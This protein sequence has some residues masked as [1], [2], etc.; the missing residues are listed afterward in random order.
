M[1]YA[2][3]LYLRALRI[4]YFSTFVVDTA[5]SPHQDENYLPTLSQFSYYFVVLVKGKVYNLAVYLRRKVYASEEFLK[6]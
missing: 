3:V 5:V 2:R 6:D 1:R 4:L